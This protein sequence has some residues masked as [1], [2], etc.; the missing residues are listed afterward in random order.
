PAGEELAEPGSPAAGEVDLLTVLEHELGHVIGLSDNAQAG[1][2]MDITLGLG[3]RRAP[4]AADVGPITQPTSIA[5]NAP[6]VAV[7]PAADLE[8]VAV[9]GSVSVSSVTVDAALASISTAAAGDD[10]AQGL[11]ASGGSPAWSVV[12]IAAIAAKPGRKD[13]SPQSA[14]ANRHLPSSLFAQLIRRPGVATGSV[15][16]PFGR[17]RDRG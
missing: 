7:V 3:V 2:L 16:K 4:T 12:R 13:R 10:D 15:L 8:P 14:L 17:D 11:T 9:N 6:T 1:D 5:V